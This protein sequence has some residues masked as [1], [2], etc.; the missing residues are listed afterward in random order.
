MKIDNDTNCLGDEITLNY[1][2]SIV[3][4]SFFFKATIFQK[5]ESFIDKGRVSPET[6]DYLIHVSRLFYKTLVFIY[7]GTSNIQ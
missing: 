2:F 7:I 5:F 1:L 4:L 6:S 3:V